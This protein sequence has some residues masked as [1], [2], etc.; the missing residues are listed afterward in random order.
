MAKPRRE[1]VLGAL[2]L[3]GGAIS[4]CA[5]LVSILSYTS[6]SHAGA[7]SHTQ[8]HRLALA[9]SPDSAASIGDTIQLAALI[10]DERGAAV[11]GARPVWTTTDPTVL[12]VDQAGTVV[13]VGAGS[14][15]AVVRV[16]ELEARRRIVVRQ[17]PA[18]LELSDSIVQVNEGERVRPAAR[19]L[20]ARG[21][22][23]AAMDP[24][25]SSGDPAVATADSGGVVSAVSPGETQLTA[26]A[27]GGLQGVLRLV[28]LPV[29]ASITVL[30][31]EGQRAA[32]GGRLAM[33]VTAQVVSRSGRPVSGVP[34]R[35][36]AAGGSAEPA[37]DTSDAQGTV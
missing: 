2:R 35:F 9:P 15:V 5:A 30:A 3:V 10:T 8:A 27:S 14:G 18:H 16:G 24:S 22:P 6:S 33:P 34:V 32:A 36:E 31:G 21:H 29:P 4:A 7:E 11:P 37:V 20:D 12:T 28:V 17:H 19:V 23:I 13:A 26:T 25:W 1:L